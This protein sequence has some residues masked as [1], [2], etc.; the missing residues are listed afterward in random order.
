MENSIIKFDNVGKYFP[1]V[2]ALDNVSFEI[3][4]GEI[5]A[6]IGENGAGKST[7]LNVLHGVFSTYEGNV[8]LKGE[9]VNFKKSIG[10]TNA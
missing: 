8:Y 7:L 6:L 2:K 9:K 1:G 5:H 10:I 4:T 3:K